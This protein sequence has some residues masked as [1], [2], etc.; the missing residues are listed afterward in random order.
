MKCRFCPR[1]FKT[2]SGPRNHENSV[3]L[4]I[5]NSNEAISTEDAEGFTREEDIV[6]TEDPGEI[7]SPWRRKKRSPEKILEKWRKKKQ[8]LQKLKGRGK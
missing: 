7:S 1:V 3:C 2:V 4:K 5:I 6:S 8:S